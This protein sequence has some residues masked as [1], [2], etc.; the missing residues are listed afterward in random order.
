M[1]LNG[2]GSIGSRNEDVMGQSKQRRTGLGK[3]IYCSVTDDLSDEHILPYALGG[4]IVLQQASCK[5]CATITGSLEQ[6]LLRG[7]WW[8]Y[9]KKLGLQTR[10]PDASNY[11][12]VLG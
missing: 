5:R 3:C 9:R 1:K 10:N 6:R 8:P 4:T 2:G 12:K 11:S 7:H